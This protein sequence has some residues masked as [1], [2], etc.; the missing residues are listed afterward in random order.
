MSGIYH[1][2]E[3]ILKENRILDRTFEGEKI[4]QGYIDYIVRK[5]WFDQHKLYDCR[6]KISAA[7]SFFEFT[8]CLQNT[9]CVVN[10]IDG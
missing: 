9:V 8:I 5:K 2:I 6:R 7:A 1:I 10:R 4:R 3:V